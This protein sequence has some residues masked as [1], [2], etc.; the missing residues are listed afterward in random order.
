M[1]SGNYKYTGRMNHSTLDYYNSNSKQYFDKTSSVALDA[2]WG[3]ADKHITNG[4]VI[5][6]LGSGSGRD[7]KYFSQQH[8]RVIGLDYS[9]SLAKI[10]HDH[11]HKPV[12]QADMRTIPFKQDAFDVVWSMA[13]LHH[14]Q[15]QDV[16]T[17]LMEIK[18]ILKNKGKVFVSVKQG[19]GEE[20]SN[21]GRFFAYYTVHEWE[22]VLTSA[23]FKIRETVMTEEKRFCD[24]SE[25]FITVPW[26]FTYAIK[27]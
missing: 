11:S 4:S 25:D 8:D 16:S 12:I 15:K 5:L 10:A 21:E 6:D 1:E 20:I 7:L 23:G 9:L 2:W 18:R 24:H 22:R 13:V 17:A 19:E 3:I 26:I 27:T 14:L